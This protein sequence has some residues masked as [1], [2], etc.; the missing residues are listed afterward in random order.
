MEMGG[1]V[2]GKQINGVFPP[3]APSSVLSQFMKILL[4]LSSSQLMD[5]NY[6]AYEGCELPA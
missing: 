6:H 1:F 2:H 5:S 3:S 4:L